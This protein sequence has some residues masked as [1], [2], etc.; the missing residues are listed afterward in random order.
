MFNVESLSM[1][2]VSKWQTR[3]GLDKVHKR[4]GLKT[5]HYLL[6]YLQLGTSCFISIINNTVSIKVLAICIFI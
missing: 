2:R 5:E 3:R 4:M 6:N 1:D